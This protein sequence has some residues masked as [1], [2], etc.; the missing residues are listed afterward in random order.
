MSVAQRSGDRREG[1][2]LWSAIY[3]VA[4]RPQGMLSQPILG[5]FLGGLV[6][7]NRDVLVGSAFGRS[8]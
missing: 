5:L 1:R 7:C 2:L 3:I 6:D 8:A 4:S